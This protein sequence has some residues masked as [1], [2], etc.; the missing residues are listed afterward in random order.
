VQPIDG[1][2]G[3]IIEQ[4]IQKVKKT[5]EKDIRIQNQ[6]LTYLSI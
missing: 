2:T 1:P 6:E 5:K 4:K 3:N